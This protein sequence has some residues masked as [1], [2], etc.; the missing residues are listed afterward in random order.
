M[1][2]ANFEPMSCDFDIGQQAVVPGVDIEC[3]PI[4]QSAVRSIGITTRHFGQNRHR[5]L[6]PVAYRVERPLN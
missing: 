5:L 1:R 2:H 3:T 4:K 6:S